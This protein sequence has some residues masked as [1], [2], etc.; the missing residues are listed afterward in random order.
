MKVNEIL[1]QMGPAP[2]VPENSTTSETFREIVKVYH[3][4]YAPGLSA[5]FE[6]NWYYFVDG[7][8]MSFPKSSVLVGH[9]A[10]FLNVLQAVKAHDHPQMVYSGVLETRLVWELARIAAF[11]PNKQNN[12][13]EQLPLVADATEAR[14]RLLVVETLL[15]GDYL[16]SN[17]LAP[18]V[19]DSDTHRVR[20]FDFWHVLAEYLRNREQPH[21][22][23]AVGEREEC[24]ARMRCLLDG[25]ENRDLLYSMAVVRELAPAHDNHHNNT[26]PQHLDESD[27][28]NR[29]AVASKFILDEAQVTGGTT[30]VVRRFSD[31]A[32]RAFVNPGINVART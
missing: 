32:V 18:P 28:K 11:M 6:T 3:E 4:V 22:P 15:C 24:L 25:R 16:D 21:G 26:A 19:Q 5:F 13:V 31:I 23:R 9:L 1:D 29:L 30:N 20:Q 14:N 17:P 2:A 8:K 10:A 12:A 7:G 27:P